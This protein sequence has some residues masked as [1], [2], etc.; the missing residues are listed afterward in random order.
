MVTMTVRHGR[1]DRLAD[2]WDAVGEGWRSITT[3]PA[4]T[5]ESEEAYQERVQDWCERGWYYEARQREIEQVWR[6]ATKAPR[7]WKSDKQP[8]QRKQENDAAYAARI[9]AW[10]N[11]G[12]A[13]DKDQKR[14]RLEETR[15]REA[16]GDARRPRGWDDGVALK[17]RVGMRERY[18]VVG[19][20]RATEVTRGQSGWHPHVH[21]LVVMKARKGNQEPPSGYEA[22]RKA[23]AL[24]NGMFTLWEK[25]LARH[26]FEAWRDSGG[27]HVDVMEATA[28]SIAGYVTK[29]AALSGL[30]EAEARQEVRG[31]LAKSVQGQALETTRGDLKKSRGEKGEMPFAILAR[32]CDGEADAVMAWLEYLDASQGRRLL[33]IGS[34]LRK[35]AKL[36]EEE[37]DEEVANK[38]EGGEEV[39]Y[40]AVTDWRERRGWLYAA[41]LLTALENEGLPG[42]LSGLDMLS[43]PWTLPGA[44]NDASPVVKEPDEVQGIKKLRTERATSELVAAMKPEDD[45]IRS[46]ASGRSCAVCGGKVAEALSSAKHLMC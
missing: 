11:E 19:M 37:S 21:V 1:S 40:V 25:G 9:A 31:G 18:G 12:R 14:R 36:G 26:G 43:I 13:F 42:L 5:G 41:E 30:S 38:D 20:V 45:T 17:R 3:S 28:E 4:W 6:G 46:S 32:A 39:L 29:L 8:K 44:V 10:K 2:L 24:A 33:L 27:L 7:G 35:L 34:E 16:F 23:H 22:H 15:V